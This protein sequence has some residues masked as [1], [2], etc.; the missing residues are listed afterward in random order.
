MVWQKAMSLSERCYRVSKRFH[1]EDQSALGNEIRR[2]CIS[3]PSNIAEGFGRYHTA[4]Y[5][6]HLWFSNGSNC[7]LQSQ[8]DLARRVE[9]IKP[10]EASML[11]ADSEEI[12]RM[13][14]GLVASLERG[15]RH[16]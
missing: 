16:S 11:I 5:V 15:T 13:L 4:E 10:D 9:L 3:I 1:R 14:R 2:T 12:G 7:E 6:R 8:V